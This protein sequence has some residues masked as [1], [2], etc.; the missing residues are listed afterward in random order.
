MRP[1]LAA[2]AVIAIATAVSGCGISPQDRPE[3]ITAPP[4]IATAPSPAPPTASNGA[5]PER[6]YFVLDGELTPVTRK[7]ISAPTPA[8][9]VRDLLAGPTEAEAADSLTSA[10]LGD[11]VVQN[12]EVANSQAV[13]TLAPPV[14]DNARNDE[15][16]AYAQLVCSLTALKQVNSV[17]FVSGGQPISVPRGDGQLSLAPLTA[18]DYAELITN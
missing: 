5:T 6:L 2:L 1:L 16:L 11:R 14:A 10:L 13:V 17:T 18:G 3:P 15:V 4:G 8:S 9:V 12:V 7:V